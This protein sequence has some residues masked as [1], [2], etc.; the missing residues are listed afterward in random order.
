M[1]SATLLRAINFAA[2]RHRHQ[3]RKDEQQLPY[4]N[5]P[6]A[7]ANLLANSG[8]ITD[9]DVLIAAVLHDVLEDTE[10]EA[11]EI[12]AKFGQTV[13]QY[14]EEVTDDK[15][16]PKQTR[17][18]LQIEHAVHASDGAKLVKLA[19]KICNIRDMS[20]SPPEGWPL[21]RRREYFDWA[22]SVVDAL[23]SINSQLEEIFSRE[24]QKRP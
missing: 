17:K 21:E 12:E 14:V 20:H 15:S 13:R 2:E 18:Q 22:K 23:G 5:H 10:T 6:I 9:E 3:R 7:V 11:D 16:L 19:D 4:I 24:Y 8:N 1:A